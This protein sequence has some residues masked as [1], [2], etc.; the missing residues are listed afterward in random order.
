MNKN[1]EYRNNGAIGVLLDEYEKAI[2]EL[3][4]TIDSVSLSELIEIVDNITKDEEC[5]SIQTILTHII[6]SG[7]TYVIEIRKWKGEQIEY[8][9]KII[10]TGIE[11]YK[12]A[13]DE[14]FK[15]NESLFKDYPE[16]QLNEYTPSKKILTRWG[17]RYDV[18]QIFAHAI[19]HVLRHRRQI[20]NF[21]EKLNKAYR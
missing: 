17:Q 19:V 16:I 21:K 6:Q 9:N 7:Y 13:I 11:E 15:F 20:E 10:L 2:N 4:Q 8:R 12:L 5:K 18:E 14:M 3:K 1:K